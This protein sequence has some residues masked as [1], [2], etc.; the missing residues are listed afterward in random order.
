[1]HPIKRRLSF[2]LLVCYHEYMNILFVCRYNNFRSKFAAAIFNSENTN[3]AHV[4][5]SAGIQTNGMPG[6]KTLDEIAV[7][8]K[9][10]GYEILSE[11]T[12]Y[13]AESIKWADVIVNVASDVELESITDKRIVIWN[14]DDAPNSSTA[15]VRTAVILKVKQK[16]LD[17]LNELNKDF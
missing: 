3:S 15:D 14:I 17:L 12:A 6:Q 1:M 11:K 9:K 13:D 16:V 7:V 8:A 2:L 5:K 4:A 10:L